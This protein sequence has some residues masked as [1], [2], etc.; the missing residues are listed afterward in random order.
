MGLISWMYLHLRVYVQSG[1]QNQYH[2]LQLAVEYRTRVSSYLGLVSWM[3][4][5]LRV[6]VHSKNRTQYR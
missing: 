2:S 3:Y 5:H 6:Y 1:T 4:L